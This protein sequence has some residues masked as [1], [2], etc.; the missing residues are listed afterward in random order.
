MRAKKID[1]NHKELAQAFQACGCSVLS[2]AS[3][4]RGAP[5]L[6][7]GFGGVT[8]LVEVKTKTGKLNELQTQFR[9]SWRGGLMIVRNI[10][11][12]VFVVNHLRQRA[13]MGAL[14]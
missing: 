9:D 5:D 12:V 6:A 8:V 11:D 14:A 1:A 7:C 4:G 3:L 10:D 13:R 2:L